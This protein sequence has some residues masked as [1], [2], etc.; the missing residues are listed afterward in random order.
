MA[1]KR[2]LKRQRKAEDHCIN[3]QEYAQKP[4]LVARLTRTDDEAKKKE[5]LRRKRMIEQNLSN[6]PES[7]NSFDANGN[8]IDTN[9]E[10]DIASFNLFTANR[11]AP[12]G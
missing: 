10:K 12:A 8:L 6:V 9:Q 11:Q 7:S 2:E 5:M 1:G 4:S 3:F